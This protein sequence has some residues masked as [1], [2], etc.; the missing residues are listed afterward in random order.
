MYLIFHK[1]SFETLLKIKLSTI[2]ITIKITN[3]LLNIK[4]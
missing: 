1:N 3:N 2:F 4:T